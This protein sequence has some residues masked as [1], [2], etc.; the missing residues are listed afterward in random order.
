MIESFAEP[1]AD[2]VIQEQWL[3]F[4]GCHG[5]TATRERPLVDVTLFVRMVDSLAARLGVCPLPALHQLERPAGHGWTSQ[6][7]HPYGAGW[8]NLGE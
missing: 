4:A 8:F 6:Q 7:W 1:L 3:S 5:A 2:M